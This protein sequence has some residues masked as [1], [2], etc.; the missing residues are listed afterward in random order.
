MGDLRVRVD[1]GQGNT[2]GGNEGS[3]TL[4]AAL[5]IGETVKS[6]IKGLGIASAIAVIVKIVMDIKPIQKIISG[7][8]KM[9]GLLLRPIADAIT[10]LL[11]PILLILKPIIRAVNQLM[12]PFLKLAM[13]FIGEGN[14]GGAI[15]SV[16]GG[17]S[18]VLIKISSELIKMSGALIIEIMGTVLGIFDEEAGETLKENLISAWFT[19]VEDQAAIASGFVISTVA[20][21]A[22]GM[23]KPLEDFALNS[24]SAVKSVYPN[25]SKEVS[26]ALD[27]VAK[28][29]ILGDFSS[30][31]SLLLGTMVT[32]F[33]TFGNKA[34]ESLRSAFDMI[35]SSI[36]GKVEGLLEI[37][38]DD[39]DITSRLGLLATGIGAWGSRIGRMFFAQRGA[40]AL[41]I[42][43]SQFAANIPGSPYRVRTG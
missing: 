10:I 16:L 36:P 9:V 15:A 14:V 1:V 41:D 11:V 5:N 42:G 22:E 20:E 24:I 25:I 33:F 34:A 27:Q 3:K 31:M 38:E 30:N 26:D 4:D 35:L 12:A 21:L 23:G 32:S 40:V 39:S 43:Q 13:Q 8:L 37:P 18:V 2:G 28:N 17:I 29:S 7:I 19:L 6:S